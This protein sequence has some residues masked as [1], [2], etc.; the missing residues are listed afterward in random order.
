MAASDLKVDV[1][2]VAFVEFFVDVIDLV[3]VK[4]LAQ[5]PGH[6]LKLGLKKKGQKNNAKKKMSCSLQPANIG[7]RDLI[8]GS[9]P[10]LIKLIEDPG[11]ESKTRQSVIPKSCLARR[12]LAI[13]TVL[14]FGR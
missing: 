14:T 4:G 8:E 11:T 9:I 5:P 10:V 1:T 6:L 12:A 7:A 2:V 13:C 3:I